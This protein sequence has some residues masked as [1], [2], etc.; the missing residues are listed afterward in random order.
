MPMHVFFNLVNG[1]E[2]IGDEEGVEAA[3]L[4]DARSQALATIRE[5]RA[6]D[7]ASSRDWVGWRLEAVDQN[8]RLLLAIDLDADT[9]PLSRALGGEMVSQSIEHLPNVFRDSGLQ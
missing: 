6:N 5:I 7:P 1:T 4:D 8:G 9:R 3:N 2:S